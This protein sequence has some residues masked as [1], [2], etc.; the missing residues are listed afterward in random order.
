VS[1]NPQKG[2]SIGL[3]KV[4][5]IT[6]A[7]LLIGILV[8]GVLSFTVVAP[9][10]QKLGV[11]LPGMNTDHQNSDYSDNNDGNNNEIDYNNNNNSSDN[12]GGINNYNQAPINPTG[13]YSGTGDFQITV[14]TPNGVYSGTMTANI[15]C[16]V[17][18]TDNNIQ[19]SV[20][21]IPTSITGSLQQVMSTNNGVQ[22]FN[23]VG[24]M[25]STTEFTANAQGN[26]GE[27][28]KAGSFNFSISGTIDQNTLTFTMNTKPNSQI[29]V[30]TQQITLNSSK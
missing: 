10:L 1:N 20:G 15:N 14:P 26:I 22:T 9:E 5:G 8:G 21:L 11:K 2:H 23:F 17:Q 6:I 18:Q 29:T 24:T 4:I 16:Q 12:T 28:N 30:S 13:I 19:L 27:G 25:T 3:G 7:A